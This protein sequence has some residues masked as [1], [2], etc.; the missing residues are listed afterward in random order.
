MKSMI[1][2]AGILLAMSLFL[3]VHGPSAV[4]AAEADPDLSSGKSSSGVIDL[5]GDMDEPADLKNQV[6]SD[7]AASG[8]ASSGQT[9][10]GQTSASQTSASQA[11]SNPVSSA[12]AGKIKPASGSSVQ[13][14][15]AVVLKLNKKAASHDWTWTFSGTAAEDA[16][17]LS[18]D[19][20]TSKRLKLTVWPSGGT[21]TVIGTDPDGLTISCDLEVSQSSVWKKRADF[22][23]N[24]LAGVSPSMSE[25]EL[26]V[27]FAEYIADR[28]SYGPGQGNFFRVIDEGVGD[29][30]CYSTAFKLLADAVGIE[31]II[32]KNGGSKSHYWNQVEIDDTWYNVDVQGY[33]TN[34]SHKWLLA[35][36]STHGF[37]GDT[38]FSL[39]HGI[40]YPVSPAHV[41]TETLSF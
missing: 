39:N 4:P 1:R 36:N 37:N 20:K 29:C 9:A 35:S 22:R 31:T 32:V 27:Y 19:Y 17:I 5:S 8:Q 18:S 24:A 28:A 7:Q 41:C 16:H 25:E 40:H 15:Q 3:A 33:D 26:V 14:G 11:S 13:T 6:S 38:S 21:L 2:K 23:A 10:S 12:N 34:R 30:W